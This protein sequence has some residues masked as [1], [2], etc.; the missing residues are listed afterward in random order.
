MKTYETSTTTLRAIPAHSLLQ[1]ENID[2]TMDALAQANQ[3]AREIDDAIRISGNVALSIDVSETELEE[4]WKALVKDM[5]VESEAMQTLKHVQA[6]TTP[7]Y[8][9]NFQQEVPIPSH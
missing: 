9:E 4:E 2:N 5:E 7:P 3:D 8:V 6:P 1:R